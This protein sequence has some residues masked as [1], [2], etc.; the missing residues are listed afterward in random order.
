MYI[1]CK[2]ILVYSIIKN[3]KEMLYKYK[4]ILEKK[5]Y[6]KNN[7]LITLG[8][9]LTIFQLTVFHKIRI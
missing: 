2:M 4:L 5:L 9:I 6:R 3:K 8:N 7:I 1:F